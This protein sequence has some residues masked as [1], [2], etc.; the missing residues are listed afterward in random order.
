VAVPVFGFATAGNMHVLGS[1]WLIVS[2]VLTGV[3]ALVLAL[4]VLPAQETVLA[5]LIGSPSGTAT[6]TVSLERAQVSRLAMLTGTFNLLWTTVTIL[7]IVRPGSTTG[8]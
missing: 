8:A 6:A 2:I 1:P 7:V 5:G 3:A 4:L